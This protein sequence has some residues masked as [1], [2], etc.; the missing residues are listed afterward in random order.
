MIY[1]AFCHGDGHNQFSYSVCWYDDDDK[2]YEDDD[3]DEYLLSLSYMSDPELWAL[4]PSSQQSW[5][6]VATVIP[7]L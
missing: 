2:E 7:S 5:R 1:S 4:R 6:V 3:D